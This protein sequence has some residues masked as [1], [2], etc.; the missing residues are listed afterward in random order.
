MDFKAN[1]NTGALSIQSIDDAR[2][3]KKKRKK[4]ESYDHTHAERPSN[5][6]RMSVHTTT[7]SQQH[8]DPTTTAAATTSNNLEIGNKLGYYA[9]RPQNSASFSFWESISRRF[10]R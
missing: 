3:R 8:H 7:S 6:A 10:D 9:P 1:H 2:S 5:P 4:T